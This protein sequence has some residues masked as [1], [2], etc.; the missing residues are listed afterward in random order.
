MG[1]SRGCRIFDSY[2][3]WIDSFNTSFFGCYYFNG[4]KDWRT[5][6]SGLLV[7]LFQY[8]FCFTELYF[9]SI[10]IQFLV[11]NTWTERME[12]EIIK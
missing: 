7:I 11:L 6:S 9:T 5:G 2:L 10:S 1:K 3:P 12:K 8:Q 4:C